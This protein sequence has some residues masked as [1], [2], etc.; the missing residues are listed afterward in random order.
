MRREAL[1]GEPMRYLS[2]KLFVT[3]RV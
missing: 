3:V 1:E 2:T